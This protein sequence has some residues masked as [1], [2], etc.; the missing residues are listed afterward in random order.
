VGLENQLG[1]PNGPPQAVFRVGTVVASPPPTA[2]VVWVQ[3]GAGQDPV[4]VPYVS[5]YVPVAGDRVV[6]AWQTTNGTLQ[7]IVI[8]GQ[9][10]Q[11]GNL[12]VN[13]EFR[14]HPQPQVAVS[15]PPYQWAQYVASGQAAIVC[16]SFSSLLQRHVMIIAIGNGIAGVNYAY[17]AAIA[18]TPGETLYG[19]LVYDALCFAASPTTLTV[20]LRVGWFANSS[21]V[22][23]NFISESVLA[24]QNTNV[25]GGDPWAISGNAV[26]PSGATYARVGIRASQAGG[27]LNYTLRVTAAELTR[28]T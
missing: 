6:I 27:N 21:N 4:D 26:V 11:A 13:G 1:D 17:S 19:D 5:P 18:V 15:K 22:Y 12:V 20:D 7:G 25:V 14:R 24:T 2:S 16:G 3:M 23:P 28:S 10:G 9:N 8:G